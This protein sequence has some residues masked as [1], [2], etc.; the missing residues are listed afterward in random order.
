MPNMDGLTGSQEPT[1]A[2]VSAAGPPDAV[3]EQFVELDD[4]ENPR[5]GRVSCGFTGV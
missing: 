1:A 3:E 4:K 5:F 2:A